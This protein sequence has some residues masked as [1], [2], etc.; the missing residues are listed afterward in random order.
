M[1]YYL[2]YSLFKED[3]SSS[4]HTASYNWLVVNNELQIMYKEAIV[5]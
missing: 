5:V 1:H 3:V 4:D 2:F